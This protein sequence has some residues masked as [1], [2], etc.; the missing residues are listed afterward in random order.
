[1]LKVFSCK[2]C[3]KKFEDYTSNR[4]GKH[5][6]CSKSCVAKF[7]F[8]KPKPKCLVCGKEVKKHRN[9][10][11]S[12]SCSNKAR[13]QNGIYRI[14]PNPPKKKIKIQCGFCGKIFM[15][16]PFREHN[17]KY[18]SS[19]CWILDL[20]KKG[21]FPLKDTTIE[22]Q[23]KEILRKLKLDFGTQYHLGGRIFD[24]YLP[25]PSLLIECDGDYWHGNPKK[26]PIL[27]E[28][29]KQH[30]VNDRTKNMIAKNNNIL[31][32]RFWGSEILE[33]PLLVKEEIKNACF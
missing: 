29:Q 17:A 23:M 4:T 28:K 32:L 18:C 14:L 9:I 5:V 27:D 2:W 12:R 15:V 6:F 13:W 3:N 16:Y 25:S 19:K 20:Y 30:Q 7:R 11:C 1:M 22:I 33:T 31:I 26:F 10:Y 21:K 8:G 24:F